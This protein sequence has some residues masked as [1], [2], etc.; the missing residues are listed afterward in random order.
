MEKMKANAENLFKALTHLINRYNR[1]MGYTYSVEHNEFMRQ[2]EISCTPTNAIT[3]D[4][5]MVAQAFMDFND[6]ANPLEKTVEVFTIPCQCI[7]VS[8]R[9]NAIV[10]FKKEVEEYLLYLVGAVED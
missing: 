5:T 2:I 6:R 8:Y 7:I 3:C 1:N 10:R 4:V 9:N